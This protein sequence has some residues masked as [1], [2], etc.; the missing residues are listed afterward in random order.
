MGYFS[1]ARRHPD[2]GMYAGISAFLYGTIWFGYFFVGGGDDQM[3]R[4]AHVAFLVFCGPIVAIAAALVARDYF[5]V[6]VLAA[7]AAARG[8]LLSID[9]SVPPALE[10]FREHTR[11]RGEPIATVQLPNGWLIADWREGRGRWGG[12]GSGGF[13]PDFDIRRTVTLIVV[14]RPSGKRIEERLPGCQRDELGEL[15][16]YY[17]KRKAMSV[18]ELLRVLG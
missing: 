7:V 9:R 18:E 6:K 4:Y 2:F 1:Y 3:L 10:K 13:D 8:G 12:Q 15:V 16:A 5:R 17:L 14:P 11:S